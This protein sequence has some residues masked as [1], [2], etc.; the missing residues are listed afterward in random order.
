MKQKTSYLLLVFFI[1]AKLIAQNINTISM[2]KEEASQKALYF[3]NLIPEGREKDY[4]FNKRSD[5]SKI[6]IE[7][8]YQTY[9]VSEKNDKLMFI[10]G[11]EWRV[12]ISVDGHF[13]SLLTLKII[14]DQAKLVD[15]GGNILAQKIQEFEKLYPN[16]VTQ[17]VIIRNTYLKQDYITINFPAICGQNHDSDFTEINTKSIQ[18]VFSLNEGLPVKTKIAVFYDETMRAAGLENDGK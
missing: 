12:P 18:P 2:I 14:K 13:I 16:A 9:Y 1:S 11:N 4:G 6:K 8:P 17:R 3:L 10:S 7:E 5:F 15:F